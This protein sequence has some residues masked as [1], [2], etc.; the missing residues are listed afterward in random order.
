MGLKARYMDSVIIL[1]YLLIL[2]EIR[3][4]IV[5]LGAVLAIRRLPAT[6]ALVK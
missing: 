6:L 1:L 4:N 5:L 2:K 3:L